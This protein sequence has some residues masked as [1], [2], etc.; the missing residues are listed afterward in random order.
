MTQMQVTPSLDV[1]RRLLKS[2]SFLVLF[3]RRV[4]VVWCIWA[5]PMHPAPPPPRRAPCKCAFAQ[6]KCQLRSGIPAPR[7]INPP[8]P[9]AAVGPALRRSQWFSLANRRPRCGIRGFWWPRGLEWR[10]LVTCR[11][12]GA[13][14]A[15]DRPWG[16]G[17]RVLTLTLEG[18]ADLGSTFAS[19]LVWQAVCLQYI[20][21]VRCK[22]NP[23]RHVL[24]CRSHRQGHVLD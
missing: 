10:G 13:A 17:G 22:S 24:D 3:H 4:V 11:R 15:P 8:A 16:Q 6:S 14:S 5:V 2:P 19:H 7:W 20:A 9:S 1:R 18:T 23:P 21:Q 12:C